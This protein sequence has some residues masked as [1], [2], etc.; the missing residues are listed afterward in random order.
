MSDKTN[1]KL[2]IDGQLHCSSRAMRTEDGRVVIMVAG[3][4]SVPEGSQLNTENGMFV[5]CGEDYGDTGASLRFI[6][7]PERC[8]DWDDGY[9]IDQ[10]L[11]RQNWRVGSP[12]K[13][14]DK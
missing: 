1:N 9:R 6:P 13:S 4:I 10:L 11:T 12:I 14:D 7:F 5:V 3:V 8:K 2:H